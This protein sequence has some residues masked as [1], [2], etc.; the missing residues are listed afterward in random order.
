MGGVEASVLSWAV[1]GIVRRIARAALKRFITMRIN[2]SKWKRSDLLQLVE[3]VKDK[4]R[5]PST[6]LLSKCREQLLR[7]TTLCEEDA[8]CL[9]SL[10]LEDA[11]RLDVSQQDLR[12]EH[13]RD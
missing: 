3:R 7:V 4:Y 9:S 8:I 1:A 5:D 2:I 10:R 12:Q 6:A 11:I 13:E